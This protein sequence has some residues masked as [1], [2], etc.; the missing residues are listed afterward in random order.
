[1]LLCLV[2]GFGIGNFVFFSAARNGGLSGLL[3]LRTRQ[4]WATRAGSYEVTP[5][6]SGRGPGAADGSLEVLRIP[7]GDVP[8]GMK[9]GLWL[10]ADVERAWC[11]EP[12]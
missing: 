2:K 7:C 10:P 9:I 11:F 1:M 4:G 6:R 12:V 5:S 3:G 8:V